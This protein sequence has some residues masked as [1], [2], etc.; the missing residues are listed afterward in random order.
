MNS[1][2]T[3]LVV[4]DERLLRLN[5][6]AFLEDLGFRVVEAARGQEAIEACVK[7]SPQLILMDIS[8]PEMNGFEACRR[9]KADPITAEPPVI[10][11]SG[12]MRTEDKVK[13]FA[14]GGVDYVTKPFHFEEVQSRIQAHLEIHRQRKRLKEQH[15]ALQSLEKLRDNL[16]HM[17]VHDMRNPLT[18]II[19]YLQI[20][21]EEL[22][23]EASH[24]SQL[25]EK[26]ML[27]TTR[28]S[29]MI[30]QMLNMSRLE[31]GS[32]P[33]NLNSCDVASLAKNA[34]TTLQGRDVKRRFLVTNPEPAFARC[35]SAIVERILENLL[36]NALRFT[37]DGGSIKIQVI[38]LKER[39]RIAVIDDGP[40]IPPEHQKSIFEKFGQIQGGL[41]GAG[42]GLGLAFCKLAVEAH[43]GEIG[44]E[45]E[46]GQGCTFWFTLPAEKP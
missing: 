19:G 12:L 17:I 41:S 18:G 38:K 20:A 2:E 27:G 8:M 14:C 1:R 6:R 24:I 4:D 11:V 16:T 32:M 15:E 9:L 23:S 25:L 10:F 5:M 21:I 26:V 3:I 44:V 29:E 39:V 34:A 28:L 40:G 7:H 13:A 46:P 37:T 43:Q 30:T 42:F 33:L 35:D 36:G 45:S 31:S 22:P